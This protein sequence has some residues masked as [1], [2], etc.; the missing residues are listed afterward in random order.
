MNTA[1]FGVGKKE[2][3]ALIKRVKLTREFEEVIEGLIFKKVGPSG[4]S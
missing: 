3:V 1:L 4:P 2:R